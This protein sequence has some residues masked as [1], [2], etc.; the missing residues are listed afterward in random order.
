MDFLRNTI[1]NFK[2]KKSKIGVVVLIGAATFIAVLAFQNCAPQK[3]SADGTPTASVLSVDE[4]TLTIAVENAKITS[5]TMRKFLNDFKAYSSEE[6]EGAFAPLSAD[7][8]SRFSNNMPIDEI[9]DQL[10]KDVDSRVLGIE[11]DIKAGHPTNS[12]NVLKKYNELVDVLSRSRDVMSYL[13]LRSKDAA[14]K[15]YIDTAISELKDQIEDIL[16]V[17]LPQ[18]KTELE[19]KLTSSIDN[20]KKYVDERDSAI[21]GALEAKIQQSQKDMMGELATVKSDL[22]KEIGTVSTVAN[23]ALDLANT[24]NAS[25]AALAIKIEKTIKII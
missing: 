14:L 21:Q 15:D 6:L 2:L 20:L 3:F 4:D 10:V 13:K 17:A 23:N 22:I 16:T 19:G 7:N 18:L 5:M 9:M 24:A 8:R 11:E 25:V 1:K 12:P